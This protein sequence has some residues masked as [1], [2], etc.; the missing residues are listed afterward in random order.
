M[1]CES[2]LKKKQLSNPFDDTFFLKVEAYHKYEKG[3]EFKMLSSFCN[4]FSNYYS[5]VSPG[6]KSSWWKK[7]ENTFDSKELVWQ[8]WETW[9][10]CANEGTL[11]LKTKAQKSFSLTHKESCCK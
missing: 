1:T 2:H 5:R 10:N 3:L 8:Q 7:N 6:E 9:F 4:K 11:S